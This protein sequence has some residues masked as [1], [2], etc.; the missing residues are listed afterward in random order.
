MTIKQLLG[1]TEKELNDYIR[2]SYRIGI[3]PLPSL[4]KRFPQIDIRF[5]SSAYMR[6]CADREYEGTPYLLVVKD[7]EKGILEARLER[8][9]FPKRE[10]LFEYAVID[11]PQDLEN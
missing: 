1:I 4:R 10:K 9:F 3:N 5:T 11:F 7:D 6:Y 8:Y 2:A